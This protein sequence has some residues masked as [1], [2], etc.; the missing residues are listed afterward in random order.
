MEDI[1]TVGIGIHWEDLP[2]GRKFRTIGRTVTET[3]IINFVNCTGMVE[4][5]FTNVEFQKHESR[6]K[7]RLAP[8]ALVYT[9][10]E[11]ILTQYVMQGVGFAFLSM[12]QEVKAPVFAGDTIHVECEVLESRESRSRPGL[13]L[14]RSLNRI[15]KQ[16]G[17]VVQV[18]K[19]LRL[20]KGKNYRAE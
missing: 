12:E 3:D 1:E 2:V 6:I 17:T 20:V 10:A 7:G 15:V 16:D 11:G 5:L 8:G 19:P 18:Y 4:V 13:G 9:F 14:V